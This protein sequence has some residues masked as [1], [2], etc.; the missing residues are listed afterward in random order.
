M[1]GRRSMTRTRSLRWLARR[2]ASTLP[3]KPAPTIS[4]S[5]TGLLRR[6][7]IGRRGRGRARGLSEAFE[8]QLVHRRPGLV[9]GAGGKVPIHPRQPGLPRTLEQ[10]LGLAHRLER[11]LGDLDEPLLAVGAYDV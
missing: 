10:R 11:G 1:C 7:D 4:Q 5:Y 8:H 9:P 6:Y 3:A 2:S